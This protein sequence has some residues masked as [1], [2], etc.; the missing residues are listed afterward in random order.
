MKINLKL[1]LFVVALVSLA[2]GEYEIFVA[3]V[4]S[5]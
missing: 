2:H 1:G 4:P 5:S 3:K